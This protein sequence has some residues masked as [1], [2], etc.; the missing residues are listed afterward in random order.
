MRIIR[1][2]FP[3]AA[4]LIAI[5][6]LAAPGP[7]FGRILSAGAGG[8]P[9]PPGLKEN[10]EFWRDVFARYKFTEVVYHDE[11]NLGRRYGTLQLGE[12]WKATRKQR[13]QVRAHRNKIRAILLALAEGRATPEGTVILTARIRNMFSGLPRREFR[14]AAY[15]V[16][17]QPG[18]RER[19]LEGYIRSGRYLSHF[20][21]IFRKHGLPEELTLLPHVESGF[22]SAIYSHAGALGLWQFTRGTGRLFMRVDGTVDARRDPFLAAEAAAKLLKRN[23]EDLN[24]WPLAI[25][26]YNH[27]ALGMRRAVKQVGSRRIDIIVKN[28]KSR[29]F[30]FASR[31]F[32]AEFLAAVEV[33]KNAKK[34]FGSVRLD[35]P[36]FFDEFYIPGFIGMKELTRRIGVDAR[37]LRKMNPALRSPVTRGWRSVPKGYPL[38]IPLGEGARVRKAYY[39]GPEGSP[40]SDGGEGSKWVLIRPGDSLGRIARR[41]RIRLGDLMKENGLEKTLIRVGDRLRLPERSSTKKRA[42]IRKSA[43]RQKKAVSQKPAAS[44]K[45]AALRS[46]LVSRQVKNKKIGKRMASLSGSRKMPQP[47]KPKKSPDARKST[48][49]RKS[50]QRVASVPQAVKRGQTSERG[51]FQFVSEYDLPEKVPSRGS[52]FREGALRQALAVSPSSG[53]SKAGWVRVQENETIGHLSRWLRVSPGR[54]RKMNRI[55]SSRRVRI[56]RKIRVSFLRVPREDFIER[57]LAYHKGIEKTFF[58]KYTVSRVKRHKLKPGENVWS[59]LMRTYRVPLWLVRHYNGNKNL[60]RITAGDEVAIPVVERREF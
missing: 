44:K 5:L 33:H 36:R 48:P 9:S 58:K 30:G 2:L 22:R 59:L 32:Y 19:F 23:F 49:A 16:R 53:G 11:Y 39:R 26:A 1:F 41:H 25:T 51:L 13:K 21:R 40:S 27:G 38:R 55:R 14:T 47:P 45:L 4:L 28:Y 35:P 52:R 31:N 46:K 29:T 43:V 56:G 60:R 17:G 42:S 57:R 15:Q 50:P 24:S 7:V 10:V 20:R 18:L 6:L 8:F 3:G 12:P 54:L 37:T 34:Y